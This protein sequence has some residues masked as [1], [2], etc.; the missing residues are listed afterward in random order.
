MEADAET[1]TLSDEIIE[2]GGTPQVPLVLYESHQ[3]E[4]RVKA[5]RV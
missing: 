2:I 3:R 1:Q 4:E 5:T